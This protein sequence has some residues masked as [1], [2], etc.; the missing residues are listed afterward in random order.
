MNT[1]PTDMK[2]FTLTIDG[3]SCGHCVQAVTRALAGVSGL[4]VKSVEVGKA[5]VT[6]TDESAVNRAIASL[7][8]AGYEARAQESSAPA[9]KAPS[10]HGNTECNHRGG[11]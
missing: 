5:E 3:M 2:S 8:E 11:Q 6:T 1:T 10:C 4:N 7:D 9:P